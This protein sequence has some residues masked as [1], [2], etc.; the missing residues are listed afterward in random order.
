MAASKGSMSGPPP[1]DANNFDVWAKFFKGYLMTQKPSNLETAFDEIDLDNE[2]E[3]EKLRMNKL[4]RK[5]YGYLMMACQN[6]SVALQIATA[7]NVVPGDCIQLY[8]LLEARFSLKLPATLNSE[9]GLFFKMKC[10]VGESTDKFVDRV[11]D[12]VTKIAN[13]GAKFVPSDD[14]IVTVL[15]EGIKDQFSTLW[16]TIFT[17]P[18]SL[19]EL[20]KL[21]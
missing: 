7:P 18:K 2:D 13:F 5:A 1:V 19:D 11:K 3:E 14:E 15:M 17:S 6:D 21:L 9:R 10:G 4:R 20:Y 8:K 12:Q 16:T